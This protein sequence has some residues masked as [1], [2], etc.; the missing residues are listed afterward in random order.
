MEPLLDIFVAGIPKPQPRPKARIAGKGHKQFVHI[1][2][3]GTAKEWKSS[4]VRAAKDELAG[5]V[6]AQPIRVT[7]EF[8]MPRPEWHYLKAGLRPNAPAWHQNESADID[9]LCKAVMDALTDAGAWTGDGLV[10][11]LAGT[12]RYLVRGLPSGCRIVIGPVND[13]AAVESLFS[14]EAMS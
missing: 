7:L 6:I 5:R 8:Y 11:Q 3:P 13:D 1:Y 9:N 4:I 12:K 14:Q 10:C 2:D